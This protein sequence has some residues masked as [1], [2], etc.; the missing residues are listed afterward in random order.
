MAVF[1]VF[2]HP[3]NSVDRTVFVKEGFSAAALIFT[4]LWALWH[5]MWIV[6]AILIAAF[7]VLY[8]LA[9]SI[10]V[11]EINIGLL[12]MLVS[13]LFGFE[14]RNLWGRSLRRAGYTE[15]GL[16]TASSQEEAELKYAFQ[17]LATSKQ[18]IPAPRLR[19]ET[20]DTLGLFGNV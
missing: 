20:A 12:D 1:A 8:G 13:L 5:R 15:A 18:A 9:P 16:V 6:S 7:G 4:V 3:D 14:A 11:N 2:E 19:H 10:G 17:R